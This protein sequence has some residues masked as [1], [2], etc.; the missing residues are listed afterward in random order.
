[1]NVSKNVWRGN[2]EIW[3]LCTKRQAEFSYS[4][5]KNRGLKPLPLQSLFA[6][7]FVPDFR[8]RFD[9]FG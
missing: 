4:M 8:V 5:R 9:I 3:N 7:V 1:M 6:D 2:G